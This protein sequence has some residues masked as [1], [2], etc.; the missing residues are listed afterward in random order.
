MTLDELKL[1]TVRV[2]DG[3]GCLFQ[4]IIAENS[5]MYILTAKHLFEGVKQDKDGNDIKFVT[6]D[7]T[8]ISIMR[9][10]NVDGHWQEQIIPFVLTKGQT[11]FP[12]KEADAAILKID[13]LQGFDKIISIEIPNKIDTYSLYGFPNQMRGNAI[14]NKDTD[15]KIRDL[16]LPATGL[17]NAQLINDTLNKLQIEGMSGGGILSIQGEN[18]Y[19]IGIQSEMKHANWANGKICFV[20]MKYFSEIINYEENNGLLTPLHPTY[21]GKFDFLQDIAFTLE[22]DF[23]DENKIE[24]T[25]TYLRNKAFEV[26]NSGLTPISIKKLFN[27][28]LLID[29]DE[30]SCLDT[31]NIWIGWLEFLTIFNIVK[32]ENLDEKLL[33]EIFDCVRLKY[34]HVE[35]CTTL[36]K[37]KLSKS[38]YTGLKK[39]NTVVIN[40]KNAPKKPFKFANGIPRNITKVQDVRGFR[41]DFGI[42]PFQSFNFVHLDYYKTECIINKL[43]EYEHLDEAQL[44]TKLKQEYHELF[45]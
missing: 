31:I 39:G 21:L 9:Q 35:D 16:G 38:D 28:K 18:I 17:K 19:I 34:T 42:D 12:H 27:Y 1:Y 32:D 10:V 40:S 6:Q 37:D 44:L 41:T 24:D 22:V 5:Y 36:F 23:I 43:E 8:E 29:E 30:F 15:Y 3:S 25:R 4:P 7:G 20:P 45:N 33:L 26:I 11:Y 13:S 2:M 14:G